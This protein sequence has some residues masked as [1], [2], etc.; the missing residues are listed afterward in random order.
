MPQGED[1][2]KPLRKALLDLCTKW[3]GPSRILSP[4]SEPSKEPLFSA[5]EIQPARG[6]VFTSLGI[7][8]PVDAWTPREHQPICLNALEAIALH[9]GDRDIHL[10][11]ALLNKVHRQDIKMVFQNR[12]LSGPICWRA[13]KTFPAVSTLHS[14]H[15]FA[16]LLDT[17]LCLNRTDAAEARRSCYQEES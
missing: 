15:S 4:V 13:Q 1:L 16:T 5:K 3:K 14:W 9:V 2:L 8:C 11:K 10:C 6:C 17:P 12:S 7:Q